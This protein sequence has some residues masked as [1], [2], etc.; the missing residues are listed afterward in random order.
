MKSLSAILLLN[1][2][3]YF[4]SHA[5]LTRCDSI[6]LSI[7]SSSFVFTYAPF[8]STDSSITFNITNNN[9]SSGWFAYPLARLEA[10]TPFPPGMTLGS[11]SNPWTVFASAWNPNET[12]PVN[13]HY[14]VSQPVPLNYIITF[15][16]WASNLLPVINDSCYFETLVTLNLN[17]STVDLPELIKEEQHLPYPIPCDES[18]NIISNAADLLFLQD[19]TGKVVGMI[20]GVEGINNFNTGKLEEGTY[21]LRNA[22]KVHK[23]IV[24]HR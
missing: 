15:R 10:I 19:A 21:Y 23:I 6:M 7:D 24:V 5:Q 18:L 22:Q 11:W 1:L 2:C 20:N 16:I 14:V 4:T 12:L 9:T 13:V 3:F 17:P 8:S